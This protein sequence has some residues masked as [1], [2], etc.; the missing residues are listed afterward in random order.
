MY[1]YLLSHISVS[2]VIQGLMDVLFNCQ[3]YN[4]YYLKI[5]FL[6]FILSLKTNI[7]ISFDKNKT[8]SSGQHCCSAFINL[9]E[10][11]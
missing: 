4:I 8:I 3:A 9:Y 6:I 5:L 10:K 1:S 2:P 7:S 11:V